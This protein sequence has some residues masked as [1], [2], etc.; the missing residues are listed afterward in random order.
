[1]FFQYF[2]CGGDSGGPIQT[3]NT[4]DITCMYTIVGVTSFGAGACG[5]KGIPG[6]YTKV[7]SYL[8]WIEGIV[9]EKEFKK[10]V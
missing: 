1:M 2:S 3:N 10:K 7:H 6:I 5:T 4:R 9:W 8:D